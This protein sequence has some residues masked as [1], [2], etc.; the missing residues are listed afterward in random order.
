MSIDQGH[1]IIDYRHVHP[2]SK[3]FVVYPSKPIARTN[4]SRFRGKH[5]PP[6]HVLESILET[7]IECKVLGYDACGAVRCPGY[8]RNWVLVEPNHFKRLK[9]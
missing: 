3:Q 9:V 6:N 8:R 2:F 5:K 1:F 4:L 7:I